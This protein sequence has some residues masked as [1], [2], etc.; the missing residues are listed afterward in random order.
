[1]KNSILILTTIILNNFFPTLLMF[2]FFIFDSNI[3]GVEIALLTS[4]LNLIVKFFQC[5]VEIPF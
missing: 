4:A 5:M 2:I 3:I 1:M